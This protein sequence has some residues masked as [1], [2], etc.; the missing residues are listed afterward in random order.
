MSYPRFWIFVFCDS[1]SKPHCFD[2][3]VIKGQIYF[4]LLS[5]FWLFHVDCV[6]GC[7]Y[8]YFSLVS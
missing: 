4:Y 5:K 3:L 8:A 7:P 1:L 2:Y 6:I